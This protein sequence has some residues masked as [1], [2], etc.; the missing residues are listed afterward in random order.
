MTMEHNDGRSD[1]LY[2]FMLSIHGLIRAHEPE[3]GRDADTGGQV[4]YVLELARAL[5][6]REEVDRVDLVTRRVI[7][8]RVDDVYSQRSEPL[9]DKA[10]ILRFHFG[11]RRYLRKERLWPHLDAM[12]D[13]ILQYFREIGRVPDVIHGHY[14]DAGYV[15]AQLARLLGVPFVFTGHS[16]GRVKRQR[17]M[18][19]GKTAE[20]IEKQYKITRRIEAEETALQTAAFVVTST[21]QEVEEQ[22][23][24]YDHYLPRQKSVIP[25]GVDLSRFRPPGRRMGRTAIRAEVERFLRHPGR[26]AVLTISR[27]DERKNIATLVEAFGQSERLREMANLVIVAG[28]RDDVDRLDSG[29]RR[30]V[31][32]LL[33]QIDRLD[34]Y[35]VAA[36]PKHHD[37]EDIPDLYRWAASTKGVFV[38][39]ALTEPFGLTLLEAA[40][41]GL[42]VVA[43]NDGG[44]NDIIRNCTNGVLIDPLDT[45]ALGQTLEESLTDRSRWQRWSRQ[46]VRGVHRHYSWERHVESFLKRLGQERGKARTY[47]AS[48]SRR[49]VLPT[50]DRLLICD[51]DNCLIG[52]TKALRRLLEVLKEHRSQIGFGI[53]SGRHA[54]SLLKVL[55]KWDIPEPD[56]LI[57]AVGS[58]IYYGKRLV[59]DRSWRRHIDHQWEP[60]KI[61]EAMEQVKGY[62]LQPDREQRRFKI[63]YVVSSK[64]PTPKE[65]VEATL[66][67]AGLKINVVFSHEAYLDVLPIRVS[68]GLA[69][70][71]L[72]FKWSLPTDRILISGDSGNDLDMLSDRDALAVV[73]GNYS[74]ELEV[75]RGWDRV[76]FA[77]GEYADG[78]LEGIRHYN[79]LGEVK[80]PEDDDAA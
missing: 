29:A 7:D 80:V 25:P 17:L 22:Y 41:S 23:A 56:L 67:S 24:L 46:G 76:Y 34:L 30:V 39:P 79:F 9:N 59:P 32:R 15:G 42:P 54:G 40:A 10:Q 45:E 52:D 73:V 62:K 11:P 50:A 69:V 78:I 64:R 36:Y 75:L 66:R 35:G 33:K 77:D 72:A 57:T 74:P 47:R 5:G 61:R 51:V 19:Q 43:T 58:E 68:K 13:R 48:V 37:S 20:S 4:L 70:R 31:T 71:H 18:D 49:S 27:A 1:G 44:P 65:D 60:E 2:I 14:A 8:Q 12:T 53:A 55:K 63:S 3:L 21:Q 28:N 26:P 38:N 16:L 6:L